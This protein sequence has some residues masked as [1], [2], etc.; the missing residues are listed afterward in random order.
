MNYR[1]ACTSESLAG[2]RAAI[3]SGSAVGVLPEIS[4]TSDLR[5][6][7][8]NP[9]LPSLGDSVLVLT[10]WDGAPETLAETMTGAIFAAFQETTLART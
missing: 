8:G 9:A 1:I 3:V 4:L 2:V 5:I 7:S 6:L 10:K